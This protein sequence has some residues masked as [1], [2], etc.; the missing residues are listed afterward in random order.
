MKVQKYKAPELFELMTCKSV[1]AWK[2]NLLCHVIK[3]HLITTYVISHSKNV[4]Q[5]KKVTHIFFRT[6]PKE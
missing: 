2:F 4:R 6:V 5:N 1:A 3:M